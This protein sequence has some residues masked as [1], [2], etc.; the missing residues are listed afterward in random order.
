MANKVVYQQWLFIS[1][2]SSWNTCKENFTISLQSLSLISYFSFLVLLLRRFPSSCPDCFYTWWDATVWFDSA[3]PIIFGCVGVL[4]N[5]QLNFTIKTFHQHIS[6]HQTVKMSLLSALHSL[7]E[8]LSLSLSLSPIMC[9]SVVALATLQCPVLY[10]YYSACSASRARRTCRP[11]TSLT[12]RNGKRKRKTSHHLSSF[13]Y[14]SNY[15]IQA[16]A[17]AHQ[18]PEVIPPSQ[19]KKKSPQTNLTRVNALKN[20]ARDFLK[21]PLIISRV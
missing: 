18:Q 17:S 13:Y 5:E 4:C 10:I 2:D 19:T 9:R 1:F 14:M 8:S 20:E 11:R 3:V 7:C 15:T 12:S 16:K 21:S 6:G